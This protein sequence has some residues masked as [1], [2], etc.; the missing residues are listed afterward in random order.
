MIPFNKPPVTGQ[1]I[2]YIQ[3]ALSGSKLSGD[4]YFAKNASSGL[5]KKPVV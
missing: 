4:G 3:E 5:L 1:E 2:Q